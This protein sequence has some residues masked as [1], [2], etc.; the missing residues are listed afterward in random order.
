M[1]SE[2]DLVEFKRHYPRLAMCLGLCGLAWFLLVAYLFC[3]ALA[4]A[5]SIIVLAFF[6]V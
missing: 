1:D 6:G 2:F 4:Y 5:I 3:Y